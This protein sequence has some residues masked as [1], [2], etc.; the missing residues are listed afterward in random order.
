[1]ANIGGVTWQ[2]HDG[3]PGEDSRLTQFDDRHFQLSTNEPLE[4]S[5]WIEATTSANASRLVLL[6]TFPGG[7]GTIT[8]QG[9]ISSAT[10][11]FRTQIWN[12]STD[13]WGNQQ[14]FSLTDD[15]IALRFFEHVLTFGDPGTHR[16]RIQRTTAAAADNTTRD[17]AALSAT[18]SIVALP[19]VEAQGRVLFALRIQASEQLSGLVESFNG[20]FSRQ[21]PAFNGT[22]WTAPAAT[23][24]PAWAFASILRGPG[25]LSPLPDAAIDAAA[26]KTWADYCDTQ[27][28]QCNG[29]LDERQS[30][31]A[32]LQNVG[33]NGRGSPVIR[34]G[35]MYSVIVDQVK[36]TPVD[37]ITPRDSSQ[38]RGVKS[39]WKVPHAIRA[40]YRDR[41]DDGFAVKEIIVYDTGFDETNATDV[42]S[43]VLFGTT[44]MTEAHRRIRYYIA[45]S[46]LRPET[47]QVEMDV[48]HLAVQRGDYVEL[49]HDV[50]LVGLGQGRV[51]KV[52]MQGGLWVGFDI[53]APV[54]L[55]TGDRHNARFQGFDGATILAEIRQQ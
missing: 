16:V 36:T 19:P 52:Y 26:L 5:T 47:F 33:A 22:Q 38:F 18:D 55:Q 21:L 45:E 35:S 3:A 12:D 8:D 41:S 15:E 39:F 46:R 2:F 6:I 4:P 28:Y 51:T 53:D 37:L 25:N 27:G 54:E 34:D 49:L 50:P 17:Q 23:T 24:N 14:T 43:L 31:W 20:V 7:L 10:V 29:V 11:A 40:F 30:A 9:A 44:S 48:K 32:A 42:R 13:T 1:M